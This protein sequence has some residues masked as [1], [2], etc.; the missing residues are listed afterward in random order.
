[1]LR[2]VLFE[3]LNHIRIFVYDC[4]HI[5]IFAMKAISS[6]FIMGCI[7][8]TCSCAKSV[9]SISL[10]HNS[11]QLL[12]GE[13]AQLT[14]SI[15]P[16][17]AKDKTIIWSVS[18]DDVVSVNDGLV[19]ALG[20]GRAIVTAKALDGGYTASCY[21]TV[22]PIIVESEDIVYHLSS[23]E[24]DLF[25]E[26]SSNANYTCEIDES[27]KEWISLAP[28]KAINRSAVTFHINSNRSYETRHGVINLI[29]NGFERSIVVSQSG[30]PVYLPDKA[31]MDF[32]VMNYDS[33]YDNCITSD[34][35]DGI[36]VLQL[37]DRNIHS[38][39]GIELFSNLKDL[40][41]VFEGFGDLPIVDVS[42][43]RRLER[44]S[45]YGCQLSK[46]ILSPS[47][48][49]SKLEI[50]DCYNNK[51]PSIDVSGCPKLRRLNCGCN[52]I[53]MLDLSKNPLLE[54][55][56]CAE[57]KITRI[58]FH[59][60][61][62][63]SYLDC[64]CNC[65]TSLDIPG[66]LCSSVSFAE[67]LIE[68][69]DLSM[70][71]NLQD[72]SGSSN[73][74]SLIKLPS[75]ATLKSVFLGDT[76][77][78][79]LD[80]S[81]CY[82]LEDV[83]CMNNDDSSS[84]LERII[85]QQGHKCKLRIPPTTNVIEVDTFSDYGDNPISFADEHFKRYLLQGYLKIDSN[86]DGEISYREAAFVNGLTIDDPASSI[87]ELSGIENF[88]NLTMLFLDGL[89]A[90]HLDLSKMHSL[91]V[92]SVASGGDL[93][94]IT[95][96]ES[97]RLTYVNI[98][99]CPL[100]KSIDVSKLDKLGYFSAS[101]CNLEAMDL[102][103]NHNLFA[104]NLSGNINLQDFKIGESAS[105]RD[106]NVA[107]CGLTSLDVSKCPALQWLV[108]SRNAFK[109][110]DVH[111]NLELKTLECWSECLEFL[112]IFKGYHSSLDTLRYEERTTSIIVK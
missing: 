23:E 54:T 29:Y 68:T 20:R 108:C 51:L 32:I 57:N 3:L 111:N 4:Q 106:L 99:W 81:S 103:N 88:V 101:D 100:L 98:A 46:L 36:Q 73:P 69:I 34:E 60:N 52:S 8:L 90:S 50:V 87:K 65:L 93:E 43:C 33:N 91:G 21:I 27:D 5:Q 18:D 25:V 75:G 79:E 30:Q 61:A 22:D 85:L 71:S 40:S 96:P 15:Q 67:N 28:T 74:L 86:G 70:Q 1:M 19:L 44:L 76:R 45:V 107:N 109:T 37:T 10:T 47:S 83:I 11:L 78:Q 35:L 110:L 56:Q 2:V 97:S 105:L 84:L 16:A 24:Q 63:L 13:S 102:S 39:E 6:L 112:Y 72:C 64:G 77:L 41:I 17:S 94:S 104:V 66:D 62:P 58:V 53:D 55:L 82:G 31:F 9:R 89:G 7:I 95:F 38:I 92:F 12:V 26:I 48:G 59:N 42:K 80:L 49:A 14:A